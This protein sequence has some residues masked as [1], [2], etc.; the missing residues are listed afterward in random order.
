MLIKN[1]W[2]SKPS[3]LADHQADGE[4]VADDLAELKNVPL[5]RKDEAKSLLRMVIGGSIWNDSVKM[6]YISI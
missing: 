3:I 2:P 5:I 4:S 1:R 6:A